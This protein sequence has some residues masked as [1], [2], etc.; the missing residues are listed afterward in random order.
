MLRSL[1]F[2]FILSFAFCSVSYADDI[3]GVLDT[4]TSGGTCSGGTCRLPT[5]N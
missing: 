4:S 3:D 2:A 1:I 5:A